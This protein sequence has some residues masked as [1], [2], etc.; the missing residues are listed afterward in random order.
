M[1]KPV[2]SPNVPA[3]ARKQVLAANRL[4]AELNTPP[5][6]T[7]A[8]LVAAAPPTAPAPTAAP[9]VE[10]DPAK[11]LEHKYNVLAGKYNSETSRLMGQVEALREENQRLRVAPVPAAAPARAEDQFNLSTVTAKER[12]EFGEELVQ[13]M[14]RIAKANSGAEVAALQA[15]VARLTGSVQTTVQ[16]GAETRMERVWNMLDSW[17]ADW[18]LVNAS[19][20]F[21][22]WLGNID[23]MSGRPRQEGL[24]QA[25]ESGDGTRVLGIFKRFVEE[26]SASRSTAPPLAAPAA[27]DQATLIAP[28]KSR[29]SGEGAPNGSSGKIWS[30]QEIS[31][32][33]SRVQRG[34][35]T[36]EEKASTEAEIMAAVTSGRVRP[37]RDDRF[38]ANSR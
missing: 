12:E 26:D 20:Q 22:D 9:V 18:R 25:F 8:A 13:L 11:K 17:N 2:I 1:T 14:A 24:T 10:E 3:G 5:S 29:G 31:D 6:A 27:L 37:T 34:R 21:V 15:Q 16:I 4:I 33:Y 19:Q 35:I 38:I 30:E 32:F 23:I 7:P 36:P 28:D